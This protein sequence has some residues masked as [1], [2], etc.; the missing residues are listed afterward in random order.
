M[1][2]LLLILLLF[3]SKVQSQDL[4]GALGAND[5]VTGATLASAITYGYFAA[6]GSTPSGTNFLIKSNA[7][8]YCACNTISGTTTDFPVKSQF[9]SSISASLTNTIIFAVVTP[10]TTAALACAQSGENLSI[11]AHYTGTFANSTY[12]YST[13]TGGNI[14]PA[15]YWS[16]GGYYYDFVG[17]N[18]FQL[19][20]GSA[21]HG[22][23]ISNLATC[24]AAVTYDLYTAQKYTCS[25]C[26]TSSSITVAVPHGSTMTIG[27]YYPPVT[28]DGYVYKITATTTGSSGLILTTTPSS[29]CSAACLI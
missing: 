29:T 3:S 1:K 25:G 18:S 13:S 20:Y 5:F 11:S 9:V 24:G 23:Y 12:L 17:N 8:T 28:P 21:G 14:M 16:S 19:V 27:S 26:T 22:Y 2:K 6:T 4:W 10:W 7:P 15:P